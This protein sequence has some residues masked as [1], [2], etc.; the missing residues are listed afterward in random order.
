MPFGQLVATPPQTPVIL[1]QPQVTMPVVKSATTTK[2][3]VSQQIPQP[4]AS[5]TRTLDLYSKHT[6]NS[7]DNGNKMWTF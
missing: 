3:P 1:D 5:R 6:T 7:F 4:C 2:A